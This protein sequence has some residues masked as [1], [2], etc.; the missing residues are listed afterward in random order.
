MLE[1]SFLSNRKHLF[2][3]R[4]TNCIIWPTYLIVAAASATHC[5]LLL[6]DFCHFFN[7]SVYFSQFNE[8][9]KKA[10][11]SVDQ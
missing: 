11:N 3:L 5:N 2:E 4:K 9:F 10:N 6:S 8:E 7:F 1:S